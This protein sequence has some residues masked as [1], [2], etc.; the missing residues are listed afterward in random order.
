MADSNAAPDRP[1]NILHVLRAPLGGLFR[2][3]V[4]LCREQ[5]RRGHRVGLIADSLT[6]GETAERVLT[7]LGPQLA[8]GLRRIP[9]RRDPH[10]TDA[11]ALARIASWTRESSADVVHGHGSKGGVYARLPALWSGRRGPVRAYT[12]HGGSLNH[13]PGSIA[14]RIYMQ[15]E[16]LLATRTDLL[17][18]ESGFIADRF[19]TSV[20][21]PPHLFK[22]VRNGIAES[23]FVPVRPMQDAVEFLYVGELRAVKGIDTLLEAL[24]IVGRPLTRPPRALLVGTGPERDALQKHADRLGIGDRIA[25]AGALPARK[26]FERGR[27]L[28]MP[29][30]AESLPYI[31]LEAAGARIPLIT[32][33]VGGIPEIFG[34]Y[35][36]RLLPPDD[37]GRLAARM[38]ES[39]SAPEAELVRSAEDLARFVQAHF[40]IETMVDGIMAAYREALAVKITDQSTASTTL[41][42]RS[43]DRGTET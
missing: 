12:P 43:Y 25:F 42:M 14:N 16:R 3:V 23:E 8:L 15:V 37:V 34:P 35:K 1:L 18:F 38:I 36:G 24:A 20:G 17:L 5:M 19:A 4:D 41:A 7:E 11:L 27:I 31:V 40:S 26:A 2:H 30:R 29:S 6:G 32:T 10:P 22:V 9:M 33:T 21:P 28:V 13:R 39:L